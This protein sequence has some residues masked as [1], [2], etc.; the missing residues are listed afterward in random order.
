MPTYLKNDIKENDSWN[1]R[2]TPTYETTD[3]IIMCRIME[4]LEYKLTCG[5]VEKI[6]QLTQHIWKLKTTNCDTLKF[7]KQIIYIT[8]SYA[9]FTSLS[10]YL[11]YTL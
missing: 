6:S 8:C 9:K 4:S 5:N 2:H 1:F 7:C 3:F 10:G 11:L